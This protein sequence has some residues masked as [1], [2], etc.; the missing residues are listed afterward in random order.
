MSDVHFGF[1][2]WYGSTEEELLASR[3]RILAYAESNE[4]SAAAFLSSGAM[5]EGIM[6]R[7]A[8]RAQREEIAKIDELLQS[9]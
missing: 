3:S 1:E 7:N 9:T 4:R 5:L 8:A 2:P 6:M